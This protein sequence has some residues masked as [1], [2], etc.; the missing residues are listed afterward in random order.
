L[1]DS[2]RTGT[3][4][5]IEQRDFDAVLREVRPTTKPWFATARN[6]AMFANEGG[7]YDDLAAYMKRNRML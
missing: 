5:M 4:R 2:I 6:V 1:S 7:V 3:V